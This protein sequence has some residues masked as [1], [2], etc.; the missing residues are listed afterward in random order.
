MA[1]PSRSTGKGMSYLFLGNVVSTVL[2]AAV[3]IYMGRLLGP[4]GYGLYAIALVTPTYLMTLIQLSIPAAATRYPA[5]YRSEGAEGEGVSFLYSMMLFQG[6]LSLVAMAVV[7]PMTGFIAGRLLNRPDVAA[8][9]PIAV[10]SVVG[11][12]LLDTGIAGFQGLNRM[13]WSARMQ[14]LQAV[15][16]AVAI[17][18]LIL[19]GFAV[20]GA[21][22]GYAICF[23]VAGVACLWL[24]ARL[25]GGLRPRDFGAHLKEALKYSLPLYAAGLLGGLVAPY[26]LTLLA[27]YAGDAAIGGYGVATN[28]AALVVLFSYPISTMIFP[29]LSGL[30][31][32]ERALRET[33]D[34]AAR[35]ASIFVVPVTAVMISLASP[36]AS[37]VYGRSYSFA[38][39]YLI[40][41]LVSYLFVGFG[42]LAQGALLSGMGETRKAMIVSAVGSVAAIVGSTALIPFFGVYG[43]AVAT[44]IDS[45]VTVVT[46]WAMI[47]RRL[48]SNV[49]L[50]KIWRVYLASG[51]AAILVYPVSLLP[52]H[53]ILIMLVG[54]LLFL[55]LVVPFMA[56]INAV[57]KEDLEALD[58]LFSSVRPVSWLFGIVLGYYG[59]FSRDRA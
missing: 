15:V 18:S 28:L 19:L 17:V 58:A 35:Y 30:A 24:A 47:R 11:N 22:A 27:N 54:G 1:A 43:A 56:L 21:V 46:G 16:K 9:I 48:G 6:G 3:A 57:S 41:L 44:A 8:I 4:A 59:I 14:V 23:I 25:H 26:E 49:T 55:A 29:L 12:A 51:A 5:K 45:G 2:T 34:K 52:L 38:G 39:G 36:I 53:P 40:V 32:D 33:Y 31:G 42:S 50:S 37:A 20:R 10:A 7:L 13:G